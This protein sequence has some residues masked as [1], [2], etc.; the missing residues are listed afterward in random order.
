MTLLIKNG[1]L[2][3]FSVRASEHSL[4]QHPGLDTYVKSL[5]KSRRVKRPSPTGRRTDANSLRE[6]TLQSIDDWEKTWT[7][8]A[9]AA[10]Q[11]RIPVNLQ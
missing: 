6:E 4:A 2:P 10:A 5:H 8:S 11:H 9:C 7:A 3:F 1:L